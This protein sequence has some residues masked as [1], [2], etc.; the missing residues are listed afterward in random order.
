MDFRCG[1]LTGVLLT[2]ISLATALA[3]IAP[4]AADTLNGTQLKALLSGRT[5]YVSAPFGALPI[6]YH[7]S[8][9]MTARSKAMAALSGG[10]TEDSGTWRIAGNQFC[11]R[12]KIWRSGTEQ[13][14]SVMR[15]GS[16]LR[17]ASN[18]GMT[19]TA[20]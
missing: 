8:G 12:W 11:Q 2:G 15:V 9:T 1:L 10:I 6:S 7:P 19:G 13:C 18:D 4:A 17:W 20:R 16:T 14:F 5:I 3:G